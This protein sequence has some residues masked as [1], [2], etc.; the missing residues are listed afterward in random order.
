MKRS[1]SLDHQGV[2]HAVGQVMEGAQLMRHGVAHAQE[3][4]GEGHTGHGGGVGHLLA[5]LGIVGAVVIGTGQ[6]LKDDLQGLERQTVGVIGS[7]HAGIGLQRVGH[8]VDTAGGGQAAGR[9]HMEVRVDDG[10]LGQQL[11]VGQRD[12]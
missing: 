9:G 8:G 7:H 6:V 11:V 3:G 12:T 2:G 4:V 5:G 10:H 1:T